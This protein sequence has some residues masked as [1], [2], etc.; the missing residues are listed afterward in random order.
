MIYKIKR[1]LFN[2][3]ESNQ[4]I[5]KNTIWLAAGEIGSRILKLVVFI[6]AARMLGV[7]EWGLFS[8]GFAIWGI[9]SIF[10]DIGI[11][12]ILI[13]EISKHSNELNQYI[14]TSFFARTALSFLSILLLTAFI[15]FFS[16]QSLKS[17]MPFLMAM[18]IIDSFRDFGFALNRAFE[19]MENE[20]LV[21]IVS[22]GLLAITAFIVISHSPRALSLIQ[23][24]V[25]AGVL[26][27]IILSLTIRKYWNIIFSSFKFNLVKKIIYEAWPV[28]TVMIFAS[29]LA[30]IDMVILGAISTTTEVGYYAVAQKLTQLLLLIPTIISA[31]L[32]PY[33]SRVTNNAYKS[34]NILSKA[35][36]VSI[37]LVTPCILITLFFAKQII[38][39]SFS[40]MYTA[41]IPLLLITSISTLF[42]IPSYFL[43]NAL[44]VYGKQRLTLRFIGFGA[45]S[46]I[47]LSFILIPHYG[48]YGAAISY[49][50]SQ[51]G[52]NALMVFETRKIE[53]LRFHLVLK[54][55][56]KDFRKD[57]TTR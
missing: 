10:S 55:L 31:A 34:K 54:S 15:P 18:I 28:G 49:T 26:G 43:S 8:Y 33:L 7:I 11:N 50:L 4:T 5:T 23:S 40:T 39:L 37:L 3:T 16:L 35:I 46:N 36:S 9:F 2:N 30:S 25:V 44:L 42:S 12:A 51:I 14:S 57:R 21:R 22:N 13:R 27:L 48:M 53:G 45:L 56:W 32:L 38:V 29:I 47:L 6:Q 19:K 17:L 24:Y 41:A 20:A 52:A 1:F